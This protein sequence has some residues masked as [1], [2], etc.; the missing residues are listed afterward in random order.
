MKSR[1][2]LFPAAILVLVC[3]VA[4]AQDGSTQVPAAPWVAFF[5]PYVDLL[6][7]AIVGISFTFAVAKIQQISGVHLQAS[8]VASLK[9]A[10]A[11]EAGVLVAGAEDNLAGRSFKIGDPFVASIANRIAA[12]FPDSKQTAGATVEDLQ[13][14][15]VG[16]IGKLQAPQPLIVAQNGSKA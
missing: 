9:S 8:A 6:V 5:S 3:A 15:V 2:A 16:E 11:T 4:Y 10:A 14:F 12:N 7:K 13:K 1:R